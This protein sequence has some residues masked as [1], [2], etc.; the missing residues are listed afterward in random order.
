M[1]IFFLILLIPTGVRFSGAILPSLQVFL[2]KAAFVSSV[3]TVPDGGIEQLQQRFAGDI[4][5]PSS[6]SSSSS[7]PPSSSSSSQS[8][9]SSSSSSSSSQTS[10][11]PPPEIDEAYRGQLLSEDMSG[12]NSGVFLNIGA[13]YLRNY[14]NL[15]F[16]TIEEELLQPSGVKI[17]DTD[18]PQVLIVHTHATESYEPYDNIFY[19][20]RNTWRS[21]DNN[22]NMIAVGEELKKS[23]EEYGISVLHD[24][25]LH[26]YPSYN[27]SYANSA[28][29]IENYLAQYPSIKVIFDVHRDAIERG[30]EVIVKPVTEIDGKKAAQLMIIAPCDDGTMGIPNWRDNARFAVEITN[31]IEADYP[32]L[33]RPIFFAYRKYNSAYRPGS[34]LLEFGSHANTLE[35]AKYTARLVGQSIGKLLSATK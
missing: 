20:K 6:S 9:S 19:D 10:S 18:E 30:G 8:L 23:L 16:E 11:L 31:Q 17:D 12:D 3:L 15:S 7:K 22:N 14:T 21:T 2:K 5:T 28:A 35:E 26:D 27:G 33:T 29:S 1:S 25:S 24:L 34:L 32:T 4:Y 13:G